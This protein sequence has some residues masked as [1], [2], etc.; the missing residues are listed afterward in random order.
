MII[1]S[2][3]ARQML[4]NRGL[5]IAV[6]GGVTTN[7]VVDFLQ[8]LLLS[9]NFRPVFYQSEYNRYESVF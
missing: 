8:L 2:K 7:E 9:A 4:E 5:R 3:Y 6:V 1:L